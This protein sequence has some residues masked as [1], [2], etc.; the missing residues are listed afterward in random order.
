MHTGK[1]WWTVQKQ[2]EAIR[3][4]ATVLPVIIS[5]DK[6]QVTL[7]RNKSAYPVYLTIGNLPKSIRQKPGRQG[8]IL[9]AYLPTSRLEHIPNKSAR[10]RTLTNLFHA[11][12]RAL[13]EPLH[14]AGKDGVTMM[15]G[16]GVSRRCHPILASYIGDYPEQCLVT[17]TYN[18]D[19]PVCLCPHSDLESFPCPYPSRDFAASVEAARSV[20]SPDFNDA[21]G[22]AHIKPVQHPFWK[23]LPHA[24][25]FQSMT[26][27]VL[28][29]LYQG[30]FKHLVAWLKEACG[31]EEIDARVARLPPN[32]SICVF[33]KGI[34][35][36]SRVSGAEHRQISSFLLGVVIDMDLPG[37]REA[38]N[39][40]VRACR[41]LLDFMYMAQYPIHSSQTLSALAE[42]LA[43]FH[44]NRQ[45]FVTLG[46][47]TGFNIPKFH[48][49]VHY[50]NC[51]KLFGTTDNYSTET[52]ER[53]HIDLA[54]DAYRATNHK[55]EYP[56]MTKW[57]EHREK[58][59]RH[60][61]Y[62]SWRSQQIV[63]GPQP[64]AHSG[65]QDVVCKPPDLDAPLHV[66]MTRHPTRQSVALDDIISPSQYGA[67]F[68]V[69]ALARFVVRW[70]HPEYSSRL[71]E[72]HAHDIL[73]PFNRLPVFHRIKFWNEHVYGKKTVDSIHVHPA[74]TGSRSGEA[75]VSARFDTALVRVRSTVPST[76]PQSTRAEADGQST[77]LDTRVVQ[78]RVV[79]SLSKKSLDFF[80]PGMPQHQRPPAHLAYVEWFSKF[81]TSPDRNA[82][83]YKV[84]RPSDHADR[85]AAILPVSLIERSVHLTPKWGGPVPR[86]WSSDT[87]LER[88]ST[89][90]V[91]PF[92]DLHTYFNVY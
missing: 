36:L 63:V 77:P 60:A 24:N 11:C 75:L 54:K 56:Q 76:L 26:V 7:F 59:V 14:C 78:V 43:S 80:F 25:I 3:P 82:K 22:D 88:C 31:T 8:Q 79:F 48:S 37:G 9:L 15:S 44:E 87:V 47:R 20:G 42:A 21:C 85:T 71:V 46:V 32:H 90:Y 52:S 58:I 73:M 55:D 72:Y 68:F 92:K 91:N 1:W 84:T 17:C 29:Q 18:G 45:I 6:T 5:S 23:D 16:D 74:S 27:D 57:L 61:D 41:A 34:S 35:N 53:L 10:R 30:V 33:Y 81:G 19:C 50:V 38:T 49:L 4:G 13:L 65:G 40:L 39:E 12:M 66:K 2:L 86:E 64:F 62:I 89:F 69:P 70:R 67:R 51:I 83:M 28:H